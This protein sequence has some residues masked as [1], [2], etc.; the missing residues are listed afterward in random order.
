[1][2]LFMHRP[3]LENLPPLSTLEA[4][5]DLHAMTADEWDGVANVLQTAFG[6]AWDAARV[7]REFVDAAD[8]IETYVITH[9]G[10]VVATASARLLPEAH[11]N[12]GY[13]H[14]VGALPGHKGKRLGYES[15][16]ATLH[17]FV[18]L[19]CRDAVLET[20]DF[21]LPAVKTY[22]NLGFVPEHRHESHPERWEAV[23]RNLQ[24]NQS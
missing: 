23:R 5:Y 15:T 9:G 7:Q 12:S 19:G 24:P 21:R 11:P 18:E 16:L 17:K 2:Q 1:M 20:D 22:L 8:V 4:D 14:Y 6:D 10:T 3:N 13:V